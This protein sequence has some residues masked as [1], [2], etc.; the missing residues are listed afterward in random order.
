MRAAVVVVDAPGELC[1]RAYAPR[2][3]A[4]RDGRPR[5]AVGGSHRLCLNAVH[6][7][8]PA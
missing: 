6:C 3:A 7:L 2:A 5:L 1:I 4:R 8:A